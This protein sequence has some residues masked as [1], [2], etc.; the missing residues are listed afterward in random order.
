M[1]AGTCEGKRA[2]PAES[3]T[4]FILR[5]K[6]EDPC[7]LSVGSWEGLGFVLTPTGGSASAMPR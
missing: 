3:S 1:L 6:D 5:R 4:A 2:A 7:W